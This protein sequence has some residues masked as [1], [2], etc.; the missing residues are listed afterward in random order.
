M[1]VAVLLA[2]AADGGLDLEPHRCR[3]ENTDRAGHR[4]STA[5]WPHRL[6][7]SRRLGR[8]PFPRNGLAWP[9]RC[10]RRAGARPPG[11]T[12][13]LDAL[14]LLPAFS[15]IAFHSRFR[16]RR[17]WATV[18]TNLAPGRRFAGADELIAS[19]TIQRIVSDSRA[20]VTVL[21]ET[22]HQPLDGSDGSV[23][24]ADA[25]G[26]ASATPVGRGRSRRGDPQTRRRTKMPH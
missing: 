26:I 1:V 25:R 22:R 14:S 3:V 7:V 15:A 20:A 6:G 13:D 9:R 24:G 16:R 2:A 5:A 11:K 17:A 23:L 19:D 18:Q 12:T 4:R 10:D 21:P 8:S